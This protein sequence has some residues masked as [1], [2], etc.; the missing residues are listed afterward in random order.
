MEL[1]DKQ[2]KGYVIKEYLATT[3][4]TYCEYSLKATEKHLIEVVLMCIHNI[5]FSNNKKKISQKYNH[6]LLL[7]KSSEQILIL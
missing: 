7:N 6:I 5:G 1:N 3:P 2:I 4:Y